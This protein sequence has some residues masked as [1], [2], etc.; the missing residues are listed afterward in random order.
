[1][2]LSG[3]LQIG[4]SALVANQAAL[5]VV[6]NNLANVATKG[7]H[8][9]SIVLAANR[10]QEIQR[11]IFVGRGVH[12]QEIN[13]QVDDALEGRIRSGVSDQS[14]S[15]AT[16]DILSQIESLQNELSDNDLSSQ[17]SEFFNA[18]SELANNPLDNSVRRVVVQKGE[19]VASYIRNLRT[20][21]TAV[22]AQ[23]DES[24]SGDVSAAN[25]L[26]SRVEELNTQIVRA[27]QGTGSAHGLRDQRDQILAELAQYVDVSTIEQSN[28][29]VDVF[30]G[31]LPV[32]L[33][34]KSRG[35]EVRRQT[36]DGDLQMDVVL[37]ADGSILQ[38]TSGRLGALIK[39]RRDDVNA[40]VDTLDT[41]AN[42]LAFEVNRAHSQG[43]G[44]KG[45]SSVTATNKV[46][47][48]NAALNAA[49]LAF[50]P[51]HG[52]FLIHVTQKS[53]GQRTTSTINVDL[54]GIGTDTTLTSLAAQLNT[55]ANVNA[56]ITPDGRL[57]LNSG[58]GDFEL[59]FSEDSSGTLAALGINTFFQGTD[60]SDLAVNSVVSGD[61][62]YVAA[63]QNH[64]SGDNR[65][66]LAI[67][68]LATRP[69]ASLGGLSISD[70]WSRHV[71]D[72]AVR[73]GQADQKFQADTVVRENLEA[74]QQSVSGVN[75][76]EEAINLLAFQRAYQGSAR[77]LSVVDEMYQTLLGLL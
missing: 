27:E 30:V 5:E 72:Y 70:Q 71:E 38:P 21:I 1:M 18:W 77:F 10:D 25:D 55:V 58:G 3:A 73:L 49:G 51:N 60:A 53:T 74:Q 19:T 32:V 59:S 62:A 63:G 20:G 24:I 26:L 54:D 41:F 68:S 45:Y 12:I 37:S 29:A 43:Q 2:S 46:S 15:A 16:R 4:R 36:I 48:A 22:R 14:A 39:S 11:G 9:Q 52:T 35:L 28:G 66:A 61:P 6:G 64:V 65:N 34:G 7:Y 69:L 23:V 44:T 42:Q 75:T 17:L 57:R 67:S 76:D 33:E 47:D 56:S 13:R 50:S 31:S 8:R 40:A